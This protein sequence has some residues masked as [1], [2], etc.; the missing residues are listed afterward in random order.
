MSVDSTKHTDPVVYVYW[1]KSKYKWTHAVKT[2]IVQGSTVLELKALFQS[3]F[4]EEKELIPL[5]I[6]E[7]VSLGLQWNRTN[8]MYYLSQSKSFY[9]FV[10][11]SERFK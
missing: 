2:Y 4:L 1:E 9:I 10:Y 6:S 11:I 5:V 8:G 3:M 7:C